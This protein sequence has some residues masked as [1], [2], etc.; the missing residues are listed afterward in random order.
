[1]RNWRRETGVSEQSIR[2]TAPFL[3]MDGIAEEGFPIS[4]NYRTVFFLWYL[5]LLLFFSSQRL[6]QESAGPALT[7]IAFL[8]L[9]FC[10]FFFFFSFSLLFLCVVF[11]S[12]FFFLLCAGI[13]RFRSGTTFCLSSVSV[14]C[15]RE[16][17][18]FVVPCQLSRIR[19]VL[20]FL[21]VLPC[22][23]LPLQAPSSPIFHPAYVYAY[24]PTSSENLFTN[25]KTQPFPPA[26]ECQRESAFFERVEGATP[27]S[28]NLNM[29]ILGHTR[30]DGK[31]LVCLF[32]LAFIVSEVSVDSVL[33]RARAHTP[34]TRGM[35]TSNR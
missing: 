25:E 12:F 11:S 17:V 35:K 9:R 22:L 10:F 24:Q 13:Q 7:A 18:V 30:T 20:I 34:K 29:D 2:H 14:A 6:K 26:S 15:C 21:F 27:E 33:G 31:R 23:S 28:I 32:C 3:S 5:H 19:V 8:P 1:M 4:P 16:M